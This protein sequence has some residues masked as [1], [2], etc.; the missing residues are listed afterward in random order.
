MSDACLDFTVFPSVLSVI[1]KSKI[2]KAVKTGKLD[3]AEVKPNLKRQD[4]LEEE[5]A[6]R[7]AMLD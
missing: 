5:E 1:V 4:A 7:D 6:I 3:M 2:M